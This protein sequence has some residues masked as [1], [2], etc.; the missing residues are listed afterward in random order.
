MKK[1][2]DRLKWNKRNKKIRRE[3]SMIDISTISLDGL[4]PWQKYH[5]VFAAK[6]VNE[7]VIDDYEDAKA[8]LYQ[9][10]FA[11]SWG[12]DR[13]GTDLWSKERDNDF[14]EQC[15]AETIV[16]GLPEIK[17]NGYKDAKISANRLKIESVKLQVRQ[18]RLSMEQ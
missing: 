15:I 3:D 9:G 11:Y 16:L 4:E 2:I 6:L 12:D 13:A 18:I 17:L 10:Y 14:L 8:C 5:W 1:N 7:G